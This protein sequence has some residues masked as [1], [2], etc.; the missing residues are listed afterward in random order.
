MLQY[1]HDPYL[2]QLQQGFS[3]KGFP[4][5]LASSQRSPPCSVPVCQDRHPQS[6]SACFLVCPAA[7]PGCTSHPAT[8]AVARG[9]FQ[10][11][12]GL[13]VQESAAVVIV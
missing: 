9:S 6:P 4:P 5:S 3:M 12:W 7:A 2:L 10:S 11:E 1:Q 13:H 8:S